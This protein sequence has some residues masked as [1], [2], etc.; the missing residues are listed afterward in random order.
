MS[1][2]N[3]A[4]TR[5]VLDTNLLVSGLIVPHGLPHRLIA[6]WRDGRF[7]LLITDAIL[8]EYAAVLT[9][10]QFGEKYGLTP[11]IIAALLRRMRAEGEQVL[12]TGTVP[13]AVRDAKDIHLLAAALGGDAEYLLTGDADLLVLNGDPAL[14]RLRIVTVRAY[15][16]TRSA[17][18]EQRNA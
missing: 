2:H 4:R 5:M 12:P 17:E 18:E 7:R 10:P 9:R 6:E 3:P 8:T 14:G 16:N 13:V 15:F 1:A 11:A